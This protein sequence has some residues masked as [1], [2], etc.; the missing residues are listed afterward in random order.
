MLEL[1]FDLLQ[2]SKS[3]PHRLPMQYWLKSFLQT[4]PAYQQYF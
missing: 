4:L 2:S 3:P 1:K